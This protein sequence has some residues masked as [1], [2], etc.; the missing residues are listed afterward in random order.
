MIAYSEIE[1]SI[2][3][4]RSL[5]SINLMHF[6]RVRKRPQCPEYPGEILTDSL[7]LI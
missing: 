7:I 5:C 4:F 1:I 6:D 3:T 2:Q